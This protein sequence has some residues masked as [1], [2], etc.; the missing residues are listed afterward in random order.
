M[1]LEHENAENTM[2]TNIISLLQVHVTHLFA[3]TVSPSRPLIHGYSSH[4]YVTHFSYFNSV[5]I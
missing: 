5:G 4:G 3:K 1:Q 2:Q